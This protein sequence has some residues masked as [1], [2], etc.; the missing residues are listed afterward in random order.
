MSQSVV[1]LPVVPKRKHL[2]QSRLIR[3]DHEYAAPKGLVR[4]SLAAFVQSEEI[5]VR[6]NLLLSDF[7]EPL[8]SRYPLYG[9]NEVLNRPHGFQHDDILGNEIMGFGLESRP[10]RL[11]RLLQKREPRRE[12]FRLSFDPDLTPHRYTDRISVGR[13]VPY[14]Y[15]RNTPCH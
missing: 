4:P 1:G 2:L 13:S 3:E 15:S 8:H 11:Q 9:A 10:P 6:G 5:V 7:G 14:E 12:S